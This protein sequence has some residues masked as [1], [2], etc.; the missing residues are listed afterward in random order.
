MAEYKGAGSE[1]D[2]AL[3]LVKRREAAS[4]DAERQRETISKANKTGLKDMKTKFQSTIDWTASQ[5]TQSTVGLVK[6]NDFKNTRARIEAEKEREEREVKE[7]LAQ[8]K[9]EDRKRRRKEQ[10]RTTVLSFDH[11]EDGDDEELA[12]ASAERIIVSSK[13]AKK[14]PSVDTSFLPDKEREDIENGIREKLAKTWLEKQKKIQDEPI[15]ITYSYWDGGGHRRVVQV[16]KGDSIRK[17]LE[18]CLETLRYEFHDLRSISVDSLLYIKEDLIIAHHFT[19]YEFIINK[20]RGKSGPLFKFDVH[21]DI[22]MVSDA[23][24]EK[25]ETHAGKIVTRSWFD[26]NKHIFPASNWEE[27]D[28][29]KDYGSYKIK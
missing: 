2:R 3:M 19:F 13:K 15:S 6:L 26:K 25:D 16:K 14:D 22:R 12:G 10:K 27:Y 1:A 23:T 21:D 4:L 9:K 28:P 7:R 5:M 29:Q 17:F 20:A 8:K 24:V 11:D 18:K